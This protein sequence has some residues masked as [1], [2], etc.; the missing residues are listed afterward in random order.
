[1]YR[2]VVKFLA[3]LLL[4]NTAHASD[5][6]R[7]Y[8]LCVP[9]PIVTTVTGFKLALEHLEPAFLASVQNKWIE[10]NV[11]RHGKQFLTSKSGEHYYV[12][13][14]K[15]SDGNSRMRIVSKSGRVEFLSKD[16]WDQEVAIHLPS[17]EPYYR[18]P[19]FFPLDFETAVVSRQASVDAIHDTFK[20]FPKL[21]F[22]PYTLPYRAARYL[23][24]EKDP[25]PTPLREVL[26]GT[27]WRDLAAIA[28]YMALVYSGKHPAILFVQDELDDE[29]KRLLD[30]TMQIGLIKFMERTWFDVNR[31]GNVLFIDGLAPGDELEGVP[32]FLFETRNHLGKDRYVRVASAQEAAQVIESLAKESGEKWDHVEIF[33]HGISRPGM[34]FIN[35]GNDYI[36]DNP[37]KAKLIFAQKIAQIKSIPL[38]KRETSPKVLEELEKANV[39]GFE[40]FPDLRDYFSK[41]ATIRL[42]S[43]ELASGIS[44]ET[45]ME[46]L[47]QKTVAGEGGTVI[48]STKPIGVAK[49]EFPP[50]KHAEYDELE[51]ERRRKTDEEVKK[52]LEKLAEP[53]SASVLF[54]REVKRH[55]LMPVF[56]IRY[57]EPYFFRAPFEPEAPIKLMEIPKR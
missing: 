33:G 11:R 50:S 51:Q 25:N 13:E 2:S 8:R 19:E 23:L 29:R 55:A 35:V 31:N 12:S 49:S 42:L 37:Q 28:G 6:G 18:E 14:E 17:I 34:S 53:S 36:V 32:R 57:A 39:V 16:R 10:R 26:A 56:F 30:R 5:C 48:G 38:E 47:G 52:L 27:L 41:G 15:D 20:F 9:H 24:K 3:L 54:T 45:L 7:I 22:Y 4:S 46:Q 21:L 1:M 44:G 40:A 43:C